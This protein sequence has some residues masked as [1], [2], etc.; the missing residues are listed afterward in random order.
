HN[1]V[2]DTQQ[3]ASTLTQQYVNNVLVKYRY[4]GGLRTTVSGS[5]E[6]PDRVLEMK[7]AVAV[8]KDMSNEEILEGYLNIVLFSGRTYGVEAAARLFFDKSAADLDIP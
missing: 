2:S 4:L 8:E 6:I 1:I 3:G 7:L 5:K